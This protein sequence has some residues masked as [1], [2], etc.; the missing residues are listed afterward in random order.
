MT[1]PAL[2][3]RQPVPRSLGGEGVRKSPS[4]SERDDWREHI[5]TFSPENVEELGGGHRGP[6]SAI[7][8]Y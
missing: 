3:L 8:S 4:A 1:R 2:H 6:T 7:L 5:A